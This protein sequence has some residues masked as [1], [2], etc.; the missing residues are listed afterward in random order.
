MTPADTNARTVRFSADLDSDARGASSSESQSNSMPRNPRSRGPGLSLSIPHEDQSAE[1]LASPGR[2]ALS[3]R[4]HDPHRRSA[5]HKSP[6]SPGSRARG[7]S[8]RSSLFRRTMENPNSAI[9]LEEAGSSGS[10]STGNNESSPRDPK[11]PGTPSVTIA[12]LPDRPSKSTKAS[13]DA[14][15]LSGLP[16]LPDLGAKPRPKNRNNTTNQGL[17]TESE[18][19][20]T[21]HSGAPSHKGWQ[22]Y[23][24]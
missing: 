10:R 4:S 19:D 24:T 22:T 11:K 7:Y 1:E 2:S 21:T 18:E 17:Y 14:G 15:N 6:L 13:K 16:N 23:C 5:A 20:Y 9:E 3:P 8:L 12:A